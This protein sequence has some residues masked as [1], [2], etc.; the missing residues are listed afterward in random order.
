M[1]LQNTS[2]I[3]RLL[4]SSQLPLWPPATS[5]VAGSLQWPRQCTSLAPQPISHTVMFKY[6]SDHTTFL[7]TLQGLPISKCQ[8]YFEVLHDMRLSPPHIFLFLWFLSPAVSPS[9]SPFQP[10]CMLSR[11]HP[12]RTLAL[13]FVLHGTLTW[14][15]LY[16]LRV[17][18]NVTCS[19]GFPDYPI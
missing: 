5:S 11:L 1:H 2:K 9:L 15:F 18:L 6:Q 8:K 16:L 10:S 4:L 19:V 13:V 14:L 7:Q 3:W 12:L 17:C